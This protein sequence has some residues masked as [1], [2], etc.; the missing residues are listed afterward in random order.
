MTELQGLPNPAEALALGDAN[1]SASDDSI[2]RR[3]SICIPLPNTIND[4]GDVRES[5][6][7][8][9]TAP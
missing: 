3:S 9:I 6:R 7:L 4:Y 2:V 8:V 1:A 5:S